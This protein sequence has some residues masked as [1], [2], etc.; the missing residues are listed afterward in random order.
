MRY[1]AARA[2]FVVLLAACFQFLSIVQTSLR[3][4]E[5]AVRIRF[6][7]HTTVILPVL[8]ATSHPVT[9]RVKLEL[10]DPHGSVRAN[11]ERNGIWLSTH[12]TVNV[13][14]ALTAI[15]ASGESVAATGA[16]T[17]PRSSKVPVLLDGKEVASVEMPLDDQL[18]GPITVDLSPYIPPGEHRV[19]LRRDAPGS[20]ASAQ[21]VVGYY[22]PWAQA[23]TSG[24]RREPASSEALRLS[25]AFN[26]LSAKIGDQVNCTVQAERI[27]FRGYGMMLA[28]IG[29]PP[30]ADVDRASL[31]RAMKESNGAINHYE[32]LPDRLI[33]YLWPQAGGAT[34]SF[35]FKP[36]FGL[37]ALTAPSILYDYY[38]PD[39]QAT[40]QP[41]LFVVQ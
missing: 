28:E 3:I 18:T 16:A 8:N 38:N 36:R 32:V 1:L 29:L 13:L 35:A 22:V 15:T 33:V 21:L 7:R 39:A 11:G 37:K 24:L 17:A 25:V 9:A 5:T 2:F 6:D 19:E 23:D 26:T 10:L 34:F 4:D 31:E 27:A 14:E 30:G 12:A 41:A 40:I 20:R